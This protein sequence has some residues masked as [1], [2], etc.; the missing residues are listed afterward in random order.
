MLERT[1]D[2]VFIVEKGVFNKQI[3]ATSWTVVVLIECGKKDKV[4]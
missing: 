1:F 3:V 2:G 4:F